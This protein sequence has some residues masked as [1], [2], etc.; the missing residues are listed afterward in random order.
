MSTADE[1]W[2]ADFLDLVDAMN[3]AHVEFLDL[4]DLAW[5]EATFP[6]P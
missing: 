2:N 5:L 4:A 6:K 1:E 3:E